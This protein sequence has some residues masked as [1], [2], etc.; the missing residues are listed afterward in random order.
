MG[1]GDSWKDNG[2]LALPEKWDDFEWLSPKKA[3]THLETSKEILKGEKPVT[4]QAQW[5]AEEAK[6]RAEWTAHAADVRKK[7]FRFSTDVE[8]GKY[9]AARKTFPATLK[10]PVALEKK[11]G[12]KSRVIV[13]DGAPTV[14]R[15]TKEMDDRR[16]RECSYHF[17]GGQPRTWSIRV[18]TSEADAFAR[19]N[20]SVTADIAFVVTTATFNEDD[21]PAYLFTSPTTGP[22]ADALR[23]QKT[24]PGKA[25]GV[26]V[27]GWRIWATPRRLVASQDP[28]HAR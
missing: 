12:E 6:I 15:E 14:M 11:S 18:E 13:I 3:Q 21:E 22:G 7:T 26:K 2:V 20:A 24:G 25:I 8:L 17:A 9:D 5:G 1:E 10:S 28:A 16:V 19:D 23:E 27:V 4:W